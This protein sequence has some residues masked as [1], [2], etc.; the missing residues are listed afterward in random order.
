MEHSTVAA[1]PGSNRDAATRILQTVKMLAAAFPRAAWRAESDAA[2]TMG[3]MSAGVAPDEASMAVRNLVHEFTQLP[4][5][6]DVLDEVQRLRSQATVAAF[7]CP[8]CRS[9][10]VAAIDGRVVLCF[11]CDWEAGQQARPAREAK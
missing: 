5:V 8:A 9:D 11:D 2:Y 4:T 3:L 6:A 10:L 7:R 1:S